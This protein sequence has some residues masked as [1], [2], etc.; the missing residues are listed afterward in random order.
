[1]KIRIRT[2][3]FSNYFQDIGIAL[4]LVGV[5][6]GMYLNYFIPIVK[7][8][9]VLMFASVFLIV[10]FK[11]VYKA[12]L[13]LAN[14]TG[15]FIA[16]FQLIMIIYGMFSDNMTFQYLSFHVYIIALFLAL[17]SNS[18]RPSYDSTIIW[19]FVI[20]SVACTLGSYI[21]IKGLLTGDSIFLFRKDDEDTILEL[22]TMSSAFLVNF[23]SALFLLNKKRHIKYIAL[24]FMLLDLYFILFLG[25]RTPLIIIIVALIIFIVKQ[26]SLNTKNI[27][28]VAVY[29]SLAIVIFGDLYFYNEN[30]QKQVDYVFTNIYLGIGVI[31][32]NS[33]QS[34][35]TGAAMGRVIYRQQAFD[36]INHEFNALNALF[37][38]GYMTLW[39]DNPLLQS[40]LDMG[41][42]GL[43]FYLILVMLYPIK[44]L[45][46]KSEGNKWILFASMF[47]LYAL[48]SSFHSGNPYLYAKYIPITI[49]SFFVKINSLNYC[50]NQ[51][52]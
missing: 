9:P 22:F 46:F 31:F 24:F 51:I 16:L 21:M 40:Y 17:S 34:D 41:V 28:R 45:W 1:M 4:A 10:S 25:K 43:F 13:P 5:P 33:G 7:W 42:I 50:N 26:K 49:L 11:N 36:I 14:K 15:G 6:I 3:A 18:P 39:L 48:F 20:S 2:Q 30:I 23:I 38:K 19:T 27:G 47:T 37:G 52:D 12:K 29:F 35:L 44:V 8:S 32:G